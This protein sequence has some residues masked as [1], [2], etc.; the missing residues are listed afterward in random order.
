V[1]PRLA[2]RTPRM[3]AMRGKAGQS[4]L[5]ALAA[6]FA[7][8][9][10]R[11]ARA[12]HQIRILDHQRAAANV[13]FAKLQKRI[14]WLLDRMDELTPELRAPALSFVPAAPQQYPRSRALQPA[15][16]AN[17][18]TM[19]AICRKWVAGQTP[20]ADPPSRPRSARRTSG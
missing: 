1:I 19:A 20:P 3:R 12:I 13:G 17:A 6:E 4:G 8:L 16:P 15:A 9:S 5:E 7:L 10:Q 14:A 2:N 11:R 18:D